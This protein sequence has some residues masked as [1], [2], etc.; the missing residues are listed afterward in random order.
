MRENTEVRREDAP[1]GQNRRIEPIGLSIR[2]RSKYGFAGSA[3]L[4]RILSSI[5]GGAIAGDEVA[6]AD[7]GAG[8]MSSSVR[9]CG[10]VVAA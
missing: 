9:A 5:V 2:V 6:D 4:G 8:E 7:D 10:V 1:H 3:H